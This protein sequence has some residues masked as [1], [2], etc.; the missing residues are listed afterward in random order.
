MRPAALLLAILP[1]CAFAQDQA[2]QRALIQRDQQTDAFQLQ[3]RQ[4]QERIA[5]PPGDVRRQQ[6]I[7]A[8]QIGDRQR[9]DEATDR[10]MRDVRP[11]GSTES[12]PYERQKAA[13]ER[14]PLLTPAPAP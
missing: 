2:V 6:E 9:L 8:R 7:D 14:R 10:Q 3:L 5:V 11:D 1:V 13:D 4:W 12:R